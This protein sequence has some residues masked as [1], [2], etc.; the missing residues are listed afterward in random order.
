MLFLGYIVR[1]K[2]KWDKKYSIF[3][4]CEK[5]WYGKLYYAVI[6]NLHDN[7]YYK[8][9]GDKYILNGV[10]SNMRKKKKTHFELVLSVDT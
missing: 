4:W 2:G 9:E 7:S 8:Q 10:N 5:K 3:V 1:K 6:T